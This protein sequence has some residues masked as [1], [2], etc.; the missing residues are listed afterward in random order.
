VRTDRYVYAETGAEQELYDLSNDPFELN[1]RHNDP[2]LAPVKAALDRL[3]AKLTSCAGKSC[4][5]KPSL[6]LQL[7]FRTDGGCVAAGV[8]AKVSGALVPEV[9]Q[10]RF[11]ADGRKAG[12]DGDGPYDAKIGAKRLDD[13]GKNR[14]AAN[15]TLLDGRE[16]T[17]SRAAPRGC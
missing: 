1:S 14:I 10:A 16:F 17:V 13:S 9:L 7:K 11:Y 2:S 6:K 4:G 8:R 12:K 5:V 3:L 15:V